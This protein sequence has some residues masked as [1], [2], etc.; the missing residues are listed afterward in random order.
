[1]KKPPHA[2]NGGH[3]RSGS[4]IN[5]P[6]RR[7]AGYFWRMATGADVDLVVEKTGKLIPVEMK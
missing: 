7:T 5:S 6:G 3:Y 4:D 1:M 2:G